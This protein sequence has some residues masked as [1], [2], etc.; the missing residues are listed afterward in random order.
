MAAEEE[1][2][3][4]R[5]REKVAIGPLPVSAST[6]QFYVGVGGPADA[7][8]GIKGTTGRL[9]GASSHIPDQFFW[10]YQTTQLGGGSSKGVGELVY[11]E[12]KQYVLDHVVLD[13]QK[14]SKEGKIDLE[15]STPLK[16][17]IDDLKSAMTAAG[18]A[19][20]DKAVSSSSSTSTSAS[21][22]SSRSVG[23][24]RELLAGLDQLHGLIQKS[25]I[26]DMDRNKKFIQDGVELAVLSRELPDRLIVYHTVIQDEQ[27]TAAYDVAS[28]KPSQPLY[29]DILSKNREAP[30]VSPSS[31]PAASWGGLADPSS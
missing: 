5:D 30:N 10:G 7:T 8:V 3:I 18:L 9:V 29:Q 23:N 17:Q 22:S 27:V 2:R 31:K 24:G 12:F 4:L 1:K 14:G 28:G 11:K 6:V 25:I 16:K 26:E 21:T 20:D 19:T 13:G 15:A